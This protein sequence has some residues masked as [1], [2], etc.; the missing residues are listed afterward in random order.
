MSAGTRVLDLPPGPSSASPRGSSGA[1]GTS[2]GKKHSG[3][4]ET[5]RAEPGAGGQHLTAPKL[6]CPSLTG[7]APARAAAARPERG[8]AGG[9]SC[10]PVAAGR[11]ARPGPA[12]PALPAE[13]SRAAPRP[14]TPGPRRED[15]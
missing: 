13:P 10:P 3:I 9:E 7:L 8:G 11:T 15:Q 6:A 1:A 2:A 5:Q 12:A 14:P 4:A